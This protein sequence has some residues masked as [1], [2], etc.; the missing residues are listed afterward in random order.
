L[1]PKTLFTAL[2]LQ[3]QE[4]PWHKKTDAMFVFTS[5][6]RTICENIAQNIAQLILCIVETNAYT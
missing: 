6:P 1:P 3:F 2:C 5:V 4:T